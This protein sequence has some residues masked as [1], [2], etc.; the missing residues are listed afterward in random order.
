MYSDKI[1]AFN[2]FG[3]EWQ[4][5]CPEEVRGKAGER[6]PADQIGQGA[7]YPRKTSCLS[8]KQT[9]PHSCRPDTAPIYAALTLPA[10]SGLDRAACKLSLESLGVFLV[11]LMTGNQFSEVP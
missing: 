11:Y 9:W 8:R 3:M 6:N 7:A 2:R 5:R 1:T 10:P 4:Y